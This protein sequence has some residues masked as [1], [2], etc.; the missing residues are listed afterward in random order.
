MERSQTLNCMLIC[1]KADDMRHS[2]N[3]NMISM[4]V[5][6]EGKFRNR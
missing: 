5:I 3:D 2:S 6:D 1:A 4:V